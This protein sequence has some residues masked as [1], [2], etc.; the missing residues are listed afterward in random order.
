[1][2]IPVVGVDAIPEARKLVDEEIM[3]G[4]VI[5]DP[6]I[7]AGVIYDM[8]MN[9]VY[10]RKP[11]DGILYNFDETGVAVRLPYKEYIG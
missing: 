10:E 4:T 9:L 11:L 2:T 1:M 7:M 3:T 8:G 5:Q 6:H